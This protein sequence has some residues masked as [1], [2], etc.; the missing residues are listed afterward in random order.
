MTVRGGGVPG[1]PMASMPC[2]RMGPPPRSSLPMRIIASWSGPL[3]PTAYK[4]VARTSCTHTRAPPRLR[5]PD[6]TKCAVVLEALTD[7]ALRG[8]AT[9]HPCSLL[10]A[11]A[12]FDRGSG[13]RNGCQVEQRNSEI[14]EN[15]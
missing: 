1:I 6:P 2:Y 5:H 10:R 11:P 13:R 4:D 14:H 7:E 15:R 9:R 12:L 8:G 3:W